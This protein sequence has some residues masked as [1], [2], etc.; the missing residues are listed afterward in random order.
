MSAEP[1]GQRLEAARR[2]VFAGRAPELAA[3]QGLLDGHTGERVLFVH[4]PGGVGKSALLGRYR[5]LAQAAGR[6]AVTVDGRDLEATPTGL[7]ARVQEDAGAH[8]GGW[9]AGL[10]LF[11]DTYEAIETIDRWVRD[12]FVPSLPA[13]AVL[14]IAGRNAPG[15]EWR[16]DAGLGSMT[17]IH[18]LRN[19]DRQAAREYARVR[20]VPP[21]HHDTIVETSFGHPLALA[22]LADASLRS[23]PEASPTVRGSTDITG[24]LLERFLSVVPNGSQRAALEVC[25]HA[26]ATTEELL[27]AVLETSEAGELFRWLRGLPF[28]DE[29]PHGLYP[30]DLAR[31]VLESD[32]YWRNPERYRTLHRRLRRYVIERF[33]DSRGREQQR[34]VFDTLFL[35]KNSPLMRPYFDWSRLHGSYVESARPDD[36]EAIV[37]LLERHEGSESAEIGR[38]W[39]GRQ[40]DAFLVSRGA[41]GRM[42]G[43]TAH[44]QFAAPQADEMEADP[45]VRSIWS[46]VSE[47]G[48]L[49]PGE[50]VV[51][52]RFWMGEDYQDVSAQSVVAAAATRLWLTTPSLA[53]SFPCVA[54]PE[55]WGP[56]FGYC[57]IERR[58][59][60]DFEVGGRRYGVFGHD[61]RIEPPSQWLDGLAERE[62]EMGLTLDEIARQPTPQLLVLSEEDFRRAVRTALREM[63]RTD[64]L[65][66][67]PLCRSRLAAGV[68][69]QAPAQRL[70]ARLREAIDGLGTTART[71]KFQEAL[72]VTFIEDAPTQEAAAD[73]L[74]V[75]FNT[76]RYRLERGIALVTERLWRQDTTGLE[77]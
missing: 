37:A 5:E 64:A 13:D 10:A 52:H 40:P 30:H 24:A 59:A 19:L 66:G 1:L 29:G 12:V 55:Q 71:R 17:R 11:I 36:L 67:S 61:W 69:G 74:G 28:V 65:A 32:L 51:V 42:E 46:F 76:Y 8:G 48:P 27:A 14:T 21:A 58:P 4:G 43:F 47:A 49:R 3:F 56:M 9:P 2:R 22:L 34:A 35:H 41:S 31:D 72:A 75:P 6:P 7:M 44:L 50:C 20:G 26:R 45:A 70:Q 18:A 38:Y 77:G 39:F 16:S 73:R 25:G 15:W 33:R 60:A 68:E 54:D 63:G 62:V 23:Q 57:N 53:W